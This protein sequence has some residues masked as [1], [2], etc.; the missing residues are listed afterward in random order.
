MMAALITIILLIKQCNSNHIVNCSMNGIICNQNS[1]NMTFLNSPLEIICENN[2]CIS[3]NVYCPES[4]NQCTINCLSY[5][6]CSNVNIYGNYYSNI[7]LNCDAANACNDINIFASNANSIA[8]NCNKYGNFSQKGSC[9]SLKT[10]AQYVTDN[11]NVNCIGTYSCHDLI[12]YAN[13]TNNVSITGVGEYALNGNI[14]AMNAANMSIS[15]TSETAKHGACMNANLYLPDSDSSTHLECIAYGCYYLSFYRHNGW[16]GAFSNINSYDCDIDYLCGTHQNCMYY[17]N[18]S[19]DSQFSTRSQYHLFQ[20]CP[21]T[22][23]PTCPCNATF[24]DL[25]RN[26]FVVNADKC[27]TLTAVPCGDN[28][29]CSIGCE[30]YNDCKGFIMDG[31]KAK[32]MTVMCGN[33]CSGAEIYCPSSGECH[34]HC[35]GCSG[36]IVHGSLQSV[37]VLQCGYRSGC[38]K[39]TIYATH[40]KEIRI[41][42]TDCYQINVFANY[43][44]VYFIGNAMETNIYAMYAKLINV[45]TDGSQTNFDIYGTNANN[46]IINAVGAGPV[47]YAE[48]ATSLIYTLQKSDHDM[49]GSST[50][51]HLSQ[52][53]NGSHGVA[54]INCIGY[55]C[56]SVYLYGFNFNYTNVSLYN[57][58]QCLMTESCIDTWW[59]YC[60]DNYQSGVDQWSGNSCASN[61]CGCYELNAQVQHSFYKNNLLNYSSFGEVHCAINGKCVIDCVGSHNCSNKEINGYKSLSL[62]VNCDSKES[63]KSAIIY[64][65]QS[66]EQQ[67]CNIHCNGYRSCYWSNIFVDTGSNLNFSASGYEAFDDAIIYGEQSNSIHAIF[68]GMN[69]NLKSQLYSRFKLSNANNVFIECK[70]NHACSQL[71]F[72]VSNAKNVTIIGHNYNR[73]LYHTVIH[74]EYTQYINIYCY[75]NNTVG[76]AGWTTGNNGC[77]GAQ[78][79][80]PSSNENRTKIACY[81]SGCYDMTFNIDAGLYALYKANVIFNGCDLCE[82]GVFGNDCM[83]KWSFNCGQWWAPNNLNS[84]GSCHDEENGYSKSSSDC[85]CYSPYKSLLQNVFVND[86]RDIQCLEI[87]T[88]SP[89]LSPTDSP[90]PIPTLYPSIMPSINPTQYP[91]NPSVYPS[92]SPVTHSPTTLFPISS[93]SSETPTMQNS[94]STVFIESKYSTVI[95]SGTSTDIPQTKTGKINVHEDGSVNVILICAIIGAIVLV[96]FMV[97]IVYYIKMKRKHG[98]CFYIKLKD[99]EQDNETGGVSLQPFAKM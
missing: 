98:N 87:N 15:C 94:E 13:F 73:T 93:L 9:I 24:T 57:N 65:P 32:S 39:A 49:S 33:G 27:M 79:Y 66:G 74:A 50:S 42:C 83:K 96:V 56:E 12:V 97:L 19:C 29:D 20:N 86:G 58:G 91:L 35:E 68:S 8:V 76:Y 16:L 78:F 11:I 34:I 67:S 77:Y 3:L 37:I 88:L 26:S 69:E 71:I 82:L 2:R 72:E 10:L 23:N 84:A 45:S 14:Y 64:C 40:S 36:L 95:I 44:N 54:Q 81:G 89:T 17:W 47:I 25:Y 70:G 22:T 99:T 85:H 48:N 18:I 6:S 31:T 75:G 5:S 43:T 80:L 53:H 1:I 38:R 30:G 60:E 61:H 4:F 92:L 59:V 51:I 62:T 63:C 41:D 90:T 46:I 55:G 28:L 7:I 21:V 52:T